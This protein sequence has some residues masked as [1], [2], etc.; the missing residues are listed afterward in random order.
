MDFEKGLILKKLWPAVF[1]GTGFQEVFK[2]KN[3]V[4]DFINLKHRLASPVKVAVLLL[5]GAIGLALVYTA[6]WS[7]KPSDPAYFSS[8]IPGSWDEKADTKQA[9]LQWMAENSAMPAHVLAKIY[10]AA[11]ETSNRDLI[12]AICLVESNFNPRAE[13]DKGAIGLMGIMPGVWLEDLKA[14]GIVRQ[15][16]D[17]YNISENIAAGAYVLA[18][19]LSETNNLSH[20]LSRYVGGAS[21]YATRVLEAQKKIELA[22]RSG[23]QIAL[24]TVRNGG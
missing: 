2:L 9:V 10:S 21:W 16:G 24:A 3:I 13:S 12:L 1:L 22:S 19:Y 17:L 11:S 15:R 8:F 6:E 20:A 18:I 7:A 14:Q 23:Q 5:I 4:T